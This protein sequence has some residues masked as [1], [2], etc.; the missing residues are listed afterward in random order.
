MYL[1]LNRWSSSDIQQIMPSQSPRISPSMVAS[2]PTHLQTLSQSSSLTSP[3]HK[4]LVTSSQERQLSASNSPTATSQLI[5]SS[6]DVV[7]GSLASQTSHKSAIQSPSVAIATHS[8][9]SSR[10]RSIDKKVHPLVASET[11]LFCDVCA[12]TQASVEFSHLVCRHLFCKGCW[13]LHFEYQILQGLSTS[14]SFMYEITTVQ[15][16]NVKIIICN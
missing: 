6:R 5:P 1:H 3:Q 7:I 8:P 10:Q 9:V 4:S 13:E 16:K 11:F 12:V 2:V 14:K 15:G